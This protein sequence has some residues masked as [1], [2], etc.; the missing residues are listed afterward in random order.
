MSDLASVQPNEDKRLTIE[1]DGATYAHYPLQTKL[2]SAGDDIVSIVKGVVEPHLEPGDLVVVSE[3]IVAISQGRAFRVEEVR[4]SFWARLLSRFVS[5]PSWGIG[6]GSP[7][8]MELALQEAGLPRILIAAALSF[9]PRLVG[10]RGLFYII[11]DKNIAAIDGPTPYT[12]PP[13]NRYAKLPP[14]DPGRVAKEISSTLGGA[15][16]AIIDANDF[17]QRV[18]GAS[19]GVHKRTVEKLFADNPLGQEAQQTPVALVRRIG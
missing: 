2:V 14:K 8:T 15:L 16:V 1:V 11:A 9:P 12:I 19:A 6:L 10:I 4:P 5:K 7:E 18:L 13:Y 17:G 3:K